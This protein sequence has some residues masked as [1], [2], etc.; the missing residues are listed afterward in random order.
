[1]IQSRAVR[2]ALPVLVGAL[3]GAVAV[4]AASATLS[5]SAGRSLGE[6]HRQARSAGAGSVVP[7]VVCRT[8]FGVTPPKR[9]VFPSSTTLAVTT[10]LAR[11][12]AAYTDTQG[13]MTVV[14]PRGWRCSASYGA[15]GSGGVSVFPRGSVAASAGEAIVG[16]ETSACFGCTTGQA[17]AL[18]PAAARAYRSAFGMACPVRRPRQERVDRL[19]STVVAFEDPP[20]VKGDGVPSGGR[21]PADGVMTYI[22]RNY[23][24]SYLETCALPADVHSTCTA[25]LNDFLARYRTR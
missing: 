15:D 8:S 23:D 13:Y 10:P 14:G 5:H 3:T 2:R 21:F 22:P 11:S 9:V 12:L 18:F 20:Y 19:S 1:V 17:C 24:G 7:L 4:G 6:M 16:S 25:V